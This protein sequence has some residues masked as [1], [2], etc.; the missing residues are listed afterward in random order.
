MAK[1]AKTR[2]KAKAPATP[3]PAKA[4]PASAPEVAKPKSTRAKTEPAKREGEIEVGV[5]ARLIMV[6]PRR[7]QQ[8]AAEGWIKKPYTIVSVVQGYIRFLQDEQ[9]KGSR[10]TE[11]NAVKA[12]RARKLRLENDATEHIT[13]LTEDA[14]AALDAI[15]GPLKSELAG[16]APRVTDDIPLRR[17]IE[18][19]IDAVLGELAKRFGKAGADLRSG[20]DAL[21]ADAPDDAEQL[22]Q[23]EPALPAVSGSAGRA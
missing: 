21:G 7:I 9:R 14:I 1:S 6:T 16:V 15:V 12:E 18:D 23:E 10:T 20:R 13:V 2:G 3:A 17:R 5:A 19:A 4:A 11:D 22:G 8:L